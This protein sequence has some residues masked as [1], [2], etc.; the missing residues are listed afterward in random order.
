MTLI[1]KLENGDRLNYED[2]VKLF[3]LDVLTLGHYANKIS[4]LTLN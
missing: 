2:G 3:D 1:E 4:L